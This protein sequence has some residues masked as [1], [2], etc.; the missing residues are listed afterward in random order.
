M[1][2]DSSDKWPRRVGAV[3]VMITFGGFGLWSLVAPLQSAAIAPGTVMVKGS[4]KTV[5]HLEGGIVAELPVRD[6]D[7]VVAGDLLVLL[8]DTQ[9]RAQLEI[10]MG[11]YYAVKAQEARL[12]AERDDLKSVVYPQLVADSV[13]PRAADAVQSQNQVFS[14]RRSAYLGEIEILKQ[15]IG[16]LGEQV[17][18]IEAVRAGQQKLVNSYSEE[19]QD[20]RELLEE[21]FADKQRLRELERNLAQTEGAVA[22]HG[23]SIAQLKMQ[24]GETRLAILQ[25]QKDFHTAVVD[26]LGHAQIEVYDL[27]ER[28]RAAADR[29]QRTAIRSPADGVVVGRTVTTIG[30]VVAPGELL[31]FIVPQADELIVE[32]QV[33][34]ADIDRVR[35]GQSAN[36]RFSAFKSATTPVMDGIVTSISADALMNEQ[37]GMSY[38]LARVELSAEGYALLADLVLVPGM[39]AEVLI[40]TGSRTLF[41]YLTQPISNAFARSLIED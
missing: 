37:T 7:T 30:E 6:G 27:D 5:E 35:N 34:P 8:D 20:F 19:L 9:P 4:R 17:H 36:I 10:A 21:G 33:Q 15:R 18:G 41:Q 23:S 25:K 12:Q 31:M 16:Q 28:V 1:Q 11:Q 38:Y 14:A 24:I 2:I 26:E 40:N 22:E 3:I 32:A 29:A 39:P 13:D